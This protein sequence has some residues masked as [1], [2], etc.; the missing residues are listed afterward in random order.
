MSRADQDVSDAEREVLVTIAHGA[1]VT[2]GG[3]SVQRAL[4]T[5]T[6][7]VLARG[8]SPWVGSSSGVRSG[9]PAGC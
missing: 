8:L 9:R 7:F 4:S 3:V 2:S 5:A 6:E 1:V